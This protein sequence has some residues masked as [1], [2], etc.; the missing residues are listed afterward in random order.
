[1]SNLTNGDNDMKNSIKVF[2]VI[3]ALLLPVADYAQG[4]IKRPKIK[5]TSSQKSNNAN[6]AR[7]KTVELEKVITQSLKKGY[8][9]LG[10]PSGTLWKATNES[11]FYDY[12]SAIRKYGKRLPSRDQWEELKD[13]CTWQWTGKGYKVSADN[14]KFIVLPAAGYRFSSGGVDNVGFW[15]YYWSS[16]PSSSKETWLLYFNSD[17]VRMSG[18]ERCDGQSVRLVQD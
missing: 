1:M 2:C 7:S 15:G 10:L 8:V 11:G 12:D 14:G 6:E 18:E 13:Y 5:S 17:N 16:T 3:F 4:Q 9:D